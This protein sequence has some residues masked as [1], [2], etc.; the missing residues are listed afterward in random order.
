MLTARKIQVIDKK[1]KVIDK[2]G[3]SLTRKMRVIYQN[4][5]N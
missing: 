5:A 4:K 2:K 3:K 1:I